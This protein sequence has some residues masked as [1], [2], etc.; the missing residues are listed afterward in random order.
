MNN[1]IFCN[2]EINNKGSL[3]AHQN[4][5][6]LN[7]NKI[8]QVRS[9]LAGRQKGKPGYL[10]WNKGLTANTD[11]RLKL[12]GEKVS[13]KYKT[14]ELTPHRTE[15]SSETKQKLSSIAKNRGLGGYVRGS[16]RGKKGWY[17]GFFCDSSYELAYVIFCLEHNIDIQRN[18]EKRQYSWNNT[19]KNYIPDFIVNNKLVEIKGY[20]TEQ[21]S[22]KILANPDITV[23]YQ[24]DLKEVFNY[25]I[26]KYGK[27]FIKLYE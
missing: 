20:K 1:C 22:A 27:D 11:K 12:A 13:E 7:P 17:K 15:H 2:R 25:V 26:N 6:N 23:L 9:P 5:C 18:T 16:G 14:G 10:V 4:C 24:S 21:W 8:K 19:I 3:I